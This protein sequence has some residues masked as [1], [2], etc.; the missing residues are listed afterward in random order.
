VTDG[1]SSTLAVGERH[2]PPADTT[3]AE[4]MQEYWQGD[5]AFLAGDRMF[6]ILRGSRY[7]LASGPYDNTVKP[8]EDPLAPSEKFGGPHPGIVMFAYLDGH[9]A[10]LT[11]DMDVDTL[12]ALSTIAGGEVVTE[13]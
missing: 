8:G 10:A 11:I 7:G 2:I 4:N 13:P 6:T 1:L 12:K 5:T 9:V 3:K